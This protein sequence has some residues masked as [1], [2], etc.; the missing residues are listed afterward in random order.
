MKKKS[1]TSPPKPTEK[2]HDG[3][4]T[5]KPHEV[6]ELKAEPI[7]EILDSSFAD[8][9]YNAGL[10][11]KLNKDDQSRL[12]SSLKKETVKVTASV[13]IRSGPLPPAEELQHYNEVLPGA[14]KTIIDMGV[15]EQDHR[16]SMDVLTVNAE[17]KYSNRGMMFGAGLLM[18]LILAAG[19]GA[20]IGSLPL[21][22]SCLGVAT[23]SVALS[24]LKAKIFD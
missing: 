6:E 16:H 23:V 3:L 21:T 15:K 17:I 19:F 10:Q 20:L 18:L 8:S 14:A 2:S 9:V 1:N 22:L 7:E 5:A 11:R 12:L 4:D 13:Q 24:F